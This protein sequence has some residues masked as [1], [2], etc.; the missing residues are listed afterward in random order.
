MRSSNVFLGFAGVAALALAGCGSNIVGTTGGAGGTGT[1]TTGTGVTTT[2]TSTGTG[3]TTTTTSTGTGTTTTTTSTGTGTTTTTTSTSTGTSSGGACGGFPC[4]PTAACGAV[5]DCCIG[6]VENAGQATFG[7]RMAELDVAR[8]AALATGVVAS[9]VGGDVQPNDA[10]CNLSG[11]G[12]FSWL[13]QFDTTASTL[14]T[15]GALPVTNPALGYSFVS[16]VIGSNMV[17]PVTY[18]GVTI[19]AD[20][21]FGTMPLQGK[22]YMPIYLDAQGMSVVVLPL[23]DPEIGTSTL[24]ANRNC[25][26][27][28]NAASLQ[29]SMNC[30][31][32]ATTPA[33]IDGGSISGLITIADA[34]TVDVT[35]LGE[36]LCVLIAGAMFSDQAAPIAHCK[37]DASGAYL[38]MGDSCSQAGGTCKDSWAFAARFA[39]SSIKINN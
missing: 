11:T 7:V 15:G 35:V 25:I 37:K 13:L 16:T 28:Y 24:S 17:G 31:A 8:P 12:Y 30:L 39:A 29:P 36:T 33:F 26:G 2:T 6:L 22:L 5:D 4:S 27:S 18:S 14:K 3:A 20:G 1:A 10:A 34:D 23:L 21:S 32:D 9:T 19:G 38:A